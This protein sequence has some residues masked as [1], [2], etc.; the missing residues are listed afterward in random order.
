VIRGA[1]AG[2]AEDRAQFARWYAPVIRAYLAARWR[3]S[4]CRQDLDDAIQEVFVACFQADGVLQRADPGRPGGFRAYLYGV[5]RNVA[6]RLEAR[7]DQDLARQAGAA[8][9]LEQ[10]A[11][12]EADLARVFDRRWAIALVREAAARQAE[13]ARKAGA[14]AERRVELLRLRFHEG[15]PIREIARRWQVEAALLHHQY[16][17]AR[18]EFQEALREVMACHQPGPPAEVERACAELLGVLE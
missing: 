3:N 13:R 6:L 7:R 17:R 9:D 8:V 11:A 10:V 15:L 2:C 18:E 12:G 16:A 14:E 1:A 5:V 4:P